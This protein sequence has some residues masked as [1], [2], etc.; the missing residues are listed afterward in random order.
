[1]NWIMSVV[2]ISFNTNAFPLNNARHVAID[3]KQSNSSSL[4]EKSHFSVE[5]QV[6]SNQV[7]LLE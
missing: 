7:D 6:D 3:D 4:F 5:M 1:M 2:L